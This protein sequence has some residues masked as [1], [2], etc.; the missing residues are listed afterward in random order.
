MDET[1]VINNIQSRYEK[2]SLTERKVAD[3]VLRHPERAVELTVKELALESV[4][5]EATVVRMCQRVGYDGYWPF[6]TM[7]ARDLGRLYQKEKEID[8]ED[9]V[10]NIFKK[11]E[12]IMST[13]AKTI[14][15][16]TL[17]ECVKVLGECK[18]VYVIAAGNTAMLAQHMGFRLGRVGIK[19][20]F[21]GM[22]EY[23]MNMINLADKE[24]V[25]VAISQT[26]ISK[27]VVTGIELA[28][29]KKLKVIA[30]SAHENSKIAELADLVLVSKGDT[31]RFDYYKSYNHL[32]EMAVIE[33]LLDLLTNPETITEKNA[34][35]LE[36][37]LSDA[38]L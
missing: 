24:D 10:K 5:S 9:T 17:L 8:E 28:K 34:D 25:V 26:G 33:A 30:I 20:S 35:I 27:T 1:R 37:L 15:K 11:Y 19:A 12:N 23:F 4:V 36:L 31:S 29:K 6:R 32:S 21:S 13:L 2:L 38:K 14:K 22:P 7:L 3:F 16:E 18:R